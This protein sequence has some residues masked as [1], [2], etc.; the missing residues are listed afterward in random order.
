MWWSRWNFA[1]KRRFPRIRSWCLRPGVEFKILWFSSFRYTFVADGAC[2]RQIS[3]IRWKILS[4]LRDSGHLRE[5]FLPAPFC[6]RSLS[7][8]LGA[9][10][11]E[12][13]SVG[14]KMCDSFLGKAGGTIECC[15]SFLPRWKMHSPPFHYL[16]FLHRSSKVTSWC[17]FWHLII[18]K[19]C[20]FLRMSLWM[21]IYFESFFHNLH[22]L[23]PSRV[24][25]GPNFSE[26]LNLWLQI[27]AQLSVVKNYYSLSLLPKRVLVVPSAYDFFVYSRLLVLRTQLNVPPS[28]RCLPCV[29]R[30]DRGEF[31]VPD[32][33]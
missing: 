32:R 24:L 19:C 18:V 15:S 29:L 30:V 4:L 8:A 21:C 14:V 28:F 12:S 2:V 27:R 17:G 23:I 7:A 3:G 22:V 6:R 11:R 25:F 16:V 33:S 26:P 10:V 20:E 9:W 31:E 5:K 1:T 13:F